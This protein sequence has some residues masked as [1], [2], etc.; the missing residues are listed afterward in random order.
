[1]TFNLT[2]DS[3]STGTHLITTK[4]DL[5]MLLRSRTREANSAT[6][7]TGAVGVVC[8]I[9]KTGDRTNRL[10]ASDPDVEWEDF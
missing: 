3:L 2:F 7:Y 10:G 8:V 1:M 9:G 5:A 6:I 4:R